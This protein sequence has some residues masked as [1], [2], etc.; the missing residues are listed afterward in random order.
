M[1]AFQWWKR[2]MAAIEKNRPNFAIIDISL[3]GS[4][5]L[6]P[7]KDLEIHLAPRCR[8]SSFDARRKLVRFAVQF[9]E[10]VRRQNKYPVSTG[11]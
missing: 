6:D 8:C 5:A 2:A 3:E 11:D 4:S 7:L 1:N 9:V 10:P